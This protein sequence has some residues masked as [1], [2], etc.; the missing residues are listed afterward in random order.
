M[1]RKLMVPF[2]III[3]KNKLKNRDGIL[4]AYFE[5]ISFY[6]NITWKYMEVLNKYFSENII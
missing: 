1:K 5:G 4:V 2:Q 6:K 3:Q